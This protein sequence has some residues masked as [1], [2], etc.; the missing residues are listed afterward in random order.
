MSGARMVHLRT[1]SDGWHAQV[2]AARL[3]ADG[4]LTQLRGNVA[5]PYPLGNV[6]VWVEEEQAGVAAA[7][8]MADE[9]EAAFAGADLSVDDSTVDLVEVSDEVAGEGCG[10]LGLGVR[11]RR[12]RRLLA[13]LTLVAIVGVPVLGRFLGS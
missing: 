1:V 9:V 8:L 2:L 5:G 13:A 10:Q 12:R 6:S 3:G 11:V 4:I 7:L